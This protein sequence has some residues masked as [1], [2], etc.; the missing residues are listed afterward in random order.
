MVSIVFLTSFLLVC[1]SVLS[2]DIMKYASIQYSIVYDQF[3]KGYRNSYP[4]YGYPLDEK[5][6][7]TTG[8]SGWTS[9]FTPGVFWNL[10]EYNRTTENLRMALDITGPTAGYSNRTD[11]DDVSFTV[12]CGFGNG[13]RL[14]KYSSYLKILLNGAHS[15][16]TRYSPK[17]RCTR[18]WD[19][20]VGFL[21]NM[22][23][24]MDL[25]LLLEASN[26]T[27]NKTYYD[28]AWQ[29][30]NRTMYEQF[31]ADNGSFHFVEYNETDGSVVRKYTAQG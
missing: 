13:Y 7:T 17:V 25:E 15:L 2:Y 22:D 31:R 28:M 18:S 6:T 8:T 23:N 5:W 14:M 1:Q 30:A 29:H 11:T 16:S 27:N 24:M 9:G 3:V 12:M 26:Q 19:S 4:Y 10:F 20:Q 21:V